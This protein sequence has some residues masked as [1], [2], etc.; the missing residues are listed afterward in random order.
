MA[1]AL[2]GSLPMPNVTR[3]GSDGPRVKP[4][5]ICVQVSLWAGHFPSPQPRQSSWQEALC[6][7]CRAGGTQEGAFRVPGRKREI[8][9]PIVHP[10]G[11]MSHP[12]VCS[13]RQALGERGMRSE[14][15]VMR[16]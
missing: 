10:R 12:G 16:W 3:P 5:A 11:G 1:G 2:E 9:C 14:T 7:L 13:L 4:E 6:D 15:P 8:L